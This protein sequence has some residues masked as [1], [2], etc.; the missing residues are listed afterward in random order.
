VNILLDA[1]FIPKIADFEMTK[2]LG[3]DFSKVLTTMRGTI[4]YLAP[5]WIS[6]VAITT[7]VDVYSYGMMLIEMILG[8]RNSSCNGNTSDEV[9]Y[10][11]VEVASTLVDG[12]VGSL[13]DS[14]LRV[15][16]NLDEAESLQGG[17]LVYSG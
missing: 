5:E 12:D 1:S 6:V 4:G 10:F 7:K 11:P 15:D 2:F 14:K 17:L 16:D 13:L 8:K 3:R 9:G